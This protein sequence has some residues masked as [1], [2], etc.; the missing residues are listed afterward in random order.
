MA[1]IDESV[2][3]LSDIYN[4]KTGT[5]PDKNQRQPAEA[6]SR[7]KEGLI[8]AATPKHFPGDGTDDRDGV[9]CS[10]VLTRLVPGVQ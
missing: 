2:S 3:C 8:S 9:R 4:A 5:D 6:V 10:G 1:K 7:E